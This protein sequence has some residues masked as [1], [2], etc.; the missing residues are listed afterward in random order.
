MLWPVLE[1]SLTLDAYMRGRDVDA[2]GFGEGDDV[3]ENAL[4]DGDG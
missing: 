2:Y 4:L 1:Y 3:G